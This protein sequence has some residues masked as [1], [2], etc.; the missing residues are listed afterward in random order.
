[1]NCTIRGW[2]LDDKESLAETLNNPHILRNLRNGIPYPYTIQDAEDYIQ[3]MMKANEQELLAFAIVVDDQ[4]VGSLSVSR[5]IDIH[6]WSGELGYYIAEPYWGKGIATSA[7][8]QACK[9]VFE[10]TDIIRI[11]AE[12]FAYNT[13][14]CRVLEKSGFQLEGTLHN[15][16]IKDGKVLDMKMYA[17]VK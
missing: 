12:P 11:F 9:H 1:M 6:S 16:A 14:S 13:A 15:Y 3:A 17:L 10:H 5:G 2:I 8:Q 7:V 4:V